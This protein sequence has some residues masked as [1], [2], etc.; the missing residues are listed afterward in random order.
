MGRLDS[1]QVR[2]M[3]EF[4]RSVPLRQLLAR[5]LPALVGSLAI[6]ELFYKFGSFTLECLGFLATWFVL[7][8]ILAGIARAL[9]R[10]AQ[11]GT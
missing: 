3:F 9:A 11:S 10:S 5:Q 4:I 2:I 8:A 1:R 6:A 7:D